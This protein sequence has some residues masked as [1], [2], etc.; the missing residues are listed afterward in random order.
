GGQ[1]LGG[2]R[3]AV[4]QD[5]VEPAGPP[6]PHALEEHPPEALELDEALAL[7]TP[8]QGFA[9]VHQQAGEQLPG[10]PTLI[11]IGQVHGAAGPRRRRA[12]ARAPG[13]DRRLLIRADDQVAFPGER[14]GALV[15]GQD[16]DGPV[17]K[18]WVSGPLPAVI[19]PGLDAVGP[20]PALDGRA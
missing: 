11:P 4:V 15:E 3:G 18:A 7:K 14:L 13:L 17:Q 20:E 1:A 9:G 8:S 5:Q 19:L 12:P 2:M 10:A 16:R 6:T